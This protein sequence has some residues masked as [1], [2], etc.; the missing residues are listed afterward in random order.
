MYVST[1][2]VYGENSF[3]SKDIFLLFYSKILKRKN[4]ENEKQSN[5]T[6]LIQSE[7]PKEKSQFIITNNW[8]FFFFSGT[9]NPFFLRNSLC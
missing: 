3:T 5:A 7:E 6:G 9:T 8:I 4:D 2:D 1:V